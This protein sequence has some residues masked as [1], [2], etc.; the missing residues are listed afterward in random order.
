M[1]V[2]SNNVSGINNP[3]KLHSVINRV[4]GYD[5]ILLQETKVTSQIL[6]QLQL[7]WRHPGG[8]FIASEELSSRRGVITLFSPSLRV[9]HLDVIRDNLG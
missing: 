9:Q 4:R 8:V 6:P 3:A 2:Y 1:K 7:K 5:I